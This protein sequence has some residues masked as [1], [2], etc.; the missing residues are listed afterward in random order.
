MP[1]PQEVSGDFSASTG[2]LIDPLTRTP[3][4][5]NII[6]PSRLD[7]V[8]SELAALWPEPNVGGA[9]SGVRNFVQNTVNKVSANS[10]I[11]KGDHFF[12]PSDRISVR[13]LKFN[14]PVTGGRVY[15]NAAADPSATDQTSDQFHITGTWFHSFGASLFSEARYNYNR[16]S[17]G[18]RFCFLRPSLR[19]WG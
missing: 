16:R 12:R 8:G 6:P 15:P 19:T 4:P 11:V 18:I 9:R 2:T 1:T 7:P 5:G 14:S 3:F 17:T 10:F 13:Y